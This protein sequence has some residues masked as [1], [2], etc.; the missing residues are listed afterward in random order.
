MEK[1][2]LEIIGGKK[3]YGRACVHAAKNAV[4]PMLAASILTEQTVTVCDCPG[5]TDIDSM[6]SILRALSV[7]VSRRGRNISV[8]GKPNMAEIPESLACAMRS[9]VFMLGALLSELGE[10]C[11]YSPG[12]CNIGA[13]P[14]DIH[15]DGLAKLGANVEYGSDYV[16]CSANRL[17]GAEI[18]LK[19]PSVGATE[20][21]IMAAVKAQ[22]ETVLVGCAR[23]PEIVSLC[24]MLR[25]MGAKLSGEGTPV[26]K[27]TGV[28]GLDGAEFTPIA[29]RIVAGTLLTAVAV[30]G[31][32]IRIDNCTTS[33]LGAVVTN[34]TSPH[35]VVYESAGGTVAESDGI[36]L[37]TDVT[38]GPYPLF[39][40]D[41]Q[42]PF[43]A[44]QCFGCGVSLTTETVFEN[45]FSHAAELRKLGADIEVER[46]EATVR[47]GGVMKGSN[48]YAS[49]LRGGAGLVVAALGSEG[50][51][52]VYGLRF[53]D[54]GYEKIEDMFSAL[55]ANIRRI[56]D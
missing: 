8:S 36:I 38:T 54:R 46:D 5:I 40:T 2:Y 19:Y 29:D 11:L 26:I 25:L 7:R 13:R 56:E 9:S 22:G 45:R 39:P 50:K 3:L 6:V 51:S 33:H 18:V 34:L 48:L 17:K 43:M 15:L 35:F 47:G 28:D 24:G 12:G 10:V 20:N 41:M 31:G 52:R 21:L 23:E 16:R 30:T 44:A 37:P 55:G 42:A 14:L 1:E 32:K 27:I 4:L 53:I 49:D